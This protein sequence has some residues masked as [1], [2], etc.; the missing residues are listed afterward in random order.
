MWDEDYYDSAEWEYERYLVLRQWDGRCAHCGEPTE[1]PHV[2]HVY[3]LNHQIYEVLCPDC[4]AEHHGNDE[5]SEYQSSEPHC[6]DC[7]KICSWEKIENKWRLMD[8]N[9][10]LHICRYLKEEAKEISESISKSIR[11]KNKKKIQ[12]SLF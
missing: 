7:G 4:H 11:I 10:K 3:G 9:G 1:S 8:S 6:K 5:I 12:K 2:H